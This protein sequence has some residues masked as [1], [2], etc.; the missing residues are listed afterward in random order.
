MVV[1]L[2][3]TKTIYS[4]PTNTGPT[5]MGF[6]KLGDE[7]IMSEKT[8]GMKDRLLGSDVVGKKTEVSIR[9]I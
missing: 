6:F 2:L 9:P 5:C 4:P 1:P 8:S 3:G 7:A